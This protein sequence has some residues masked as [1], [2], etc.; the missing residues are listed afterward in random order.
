MIYSV[1]NYTI[2]YNFR[3]FILISSKRCALS[4]LFIVSTYCTDRFFIRPFYWLTT[5][6]LVWIHHRTYVSKLIQTNIS[7]THTY[8]YDW[9]YIYYHTYIHHIQIV[10]YL[11]TYSNL[12]TINYIYYYIMYIYIHFIHLSHYYIDIY[13][14]IH[15]YPL[16]ATRRRPL[17]GPMELPRH[18]NYATTASLGG[19][20]WF[21]GLSKKNGLGLMGFNGV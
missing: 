3:A 14:Y 18:C 10:T 9:I 16:S 21:L 11:I 4:N 5:H 6:P 20:T 13:I 15:V 17:F 19:T 1:S 8:I 7:H 2:L 12:I